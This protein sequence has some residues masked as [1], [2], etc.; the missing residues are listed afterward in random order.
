[1]TAS[2]PQSTATPE[3]FASCV[4]LSTPP[5]PVPTLSQHAGERAGCWRPHRPSLSAPVTPTEALCGQRTVR[6]DAASGGAP[7]CQ[8]LAP[9]CGCTAPRTWALGRDPG[10]RPRSLAHAG[11]GLSNLCPQSGGALGPSPPPGV[12]TPESEPSPP[13]PGDPAV[14]TPSPFSERDSGAREPRSLPPSPPHPHPGCPLPW[15]T[16]LSFAQRLL[17]PIGAHI[18]GVL[19]WVWVWVWEVVGGGAPAPI[20]A[21]GRHDALGPGPTGPPAAPP[22]AS[23][24]VPPVG[25]G[26]RSVPAPPAAPHLSGGPQGAGLGPPPVGGPRSWGRGGWPGGVR[27]RE[28]AWPG[29]AARP[30]LPSPFLAGPP[31]PAPPPAGGV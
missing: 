5:H 16:C 20:L 27:P 7:P 2:H 12:G 10:C 3:G 26:G 4:H 22:A 21:P 1:M 9:A 28:S 6:R 8:R 11:A 24:P 18:L 17:Q 23:R 19:G 15:L 31:L 14:W 25:A 30:P 13:Q 29:G